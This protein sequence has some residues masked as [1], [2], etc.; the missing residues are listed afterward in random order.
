MRVTGFSSPFGSYART[1]TL[2]A[3]QALGENYPRELARVLEIG[4]ASVQRA[5]KS[6]ERDGLV[7]A[8]SVEERASIASI[9]ESL[10]D[11]SWSAIWSGFSTPS[12][13]FGKGPQLCAGV[14]GAPESL[15]EAEPGVFS[16]RLRRC[17]RQRAIVRRNN[18]PIAPPEYQP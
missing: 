7:V 18:V 6:F 4:L 8:R 13:S 17:R 9:P 1:R 2:L 15:F 16:G 10:A 11:P 3:I 12:R 5:L 14:P